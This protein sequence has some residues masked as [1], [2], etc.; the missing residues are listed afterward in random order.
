M[1]A[2]FS[3]DLGLQDIILEG[4]SITVVNALKSSSPNWS[5][6]G[7]IIEDVRE[8]LFSRRRWDALHVKREAN[9]AAHVL[10]RKMPLLR[11]RRRFGWRK[12]HLVFFLLLI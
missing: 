9:M 10:M 7:Q 6:F 12:A 1:A 5:L 8:I 4:D 3:H 11:L 2:E